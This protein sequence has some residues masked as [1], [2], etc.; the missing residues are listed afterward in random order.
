M[1]TQAALAQWSKLAHTT[2]YQGRK[3][4]INQMVMAKLTHIIKVLPPT[5]EFI[6]SVQQM[7]VNFI[8]NGRYWLNPHYY[9]F[10]EL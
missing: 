10:G 2:S 1:K 9:V 6:T 5:P 4:A 8:W 3:R 7:Y